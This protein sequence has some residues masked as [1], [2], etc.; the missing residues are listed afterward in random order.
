MIGKNFG[1]T[2][3]SGTKRKSMFDTHKSRKSFTISDYRRVHATSI[4]ATL[5]KHKFFLA[6][7]TAQHF[8][9][10]PPYANVAMASLRM[11]SDGGEA[12]ISWDLSPEGHCML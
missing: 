1:E 2:K 7:S 9:L 3:L 5:L 12:V 6:R 10:R 4:W 8:F 11:Q